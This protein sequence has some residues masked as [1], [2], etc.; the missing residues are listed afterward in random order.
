MRGSVTSV[1]AMLTSTAYSHANI[2]IYCLNMTSF[3]SCFAAVNFYLIIVLDGASAPPNSSCDIVLIADSYIIYF[4]KIRILCLPGCRYIVNINVNVENKRAIFHVNMGEEHSEKEGCMGAFTN[5]TKNKHQS[6]KPTS[7]DNKCPSQIKTAAKAVHNKFKHNAC[8]HCEYTAIHPVHLKRHIK[9]VHEKFTDYACP[10]CEYITTRASHL[11][12][13][14]TGVHLHVRLQ[15]GRVGRCVLTLRASII[16][17]LV[18]Y[19]LG[20]HL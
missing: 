15:A 4:Y 7:Q 12:A 5:V 16:S 17:N 1:L 8:P 11:K 9:E 14:I 13:H 18:M 2:F 10:H 19:S 20:M 3:S 6:K